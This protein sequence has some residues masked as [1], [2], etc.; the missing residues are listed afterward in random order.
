MERIKSEK[1]KM[2]VVL[3][4]H[5]SGTSV[6]TR[7]LQALGVNLGNEL[8]PPQEDNVTGFW[9]DVDLNALNI[10][11]L[12]FLNQDWHFLTPIQQS[13]MNEL[14]KAG[15]LLKATDLL[16]KK[17]SNVPI[18]G[19]KDPRVAKL[20]PFWKE[21]FAEN[22]LQVGYVISIRHPLSVCKSLEKRHGFDFEKS[23]LLW[24]EHVINSLADTE[25]EKR[26]LVDYDHLMQSPETTLQRIAKLLQLQINILELD[27][28]K[29]EFLN[30]AL[31]HT[32]YP[33]EDLMLEKS[34]GSLAGEIYSTL[35]V[36]NQGMKL[37]GIKIKKKITQWKK[38][39]A[40]T[41]AALTF[42]DKLN[43]RIEN[44]VTG[45][46]KREQALVERI[47]EQDTQI[48]KLTNQLNE[49]EGSKAW[50]I[51]MFL[52]RIRIW[53]TPSRT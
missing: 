42:I 35:I 34:I 45:N 53:L 6:I 27:K 10:E 40:K 8:L 14:R 17:T 29:N 43:L 15:Y 21:V 9:E 3:G 41:A 49:I 39:Y 11:M 12:H 30:E 1:N 52:R 47:S 18:F 26:V 4:M 31:R 7:G 36:N 38:E 25:G 22:R 46:I 5:R 50:Q 37:E 24:L 19:F 48:Q 28:F 23:S 20:L 44:I 32:M 2:I 16:K 13:D 33:Y 51:V